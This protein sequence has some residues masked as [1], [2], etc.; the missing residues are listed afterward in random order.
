MAPGPGG[1][2][3]DASEA[4]PDRSAPPDP[5]PA[6]PV[7]VLTKFVDGRAV[8]FPPLGQSQDASANADSPSSLGPDEGPLTL[9]QAYLQYAARQN[10]ARAADIADAP[11]LA[12]PRAYLDLRGLP[13]RPGPVAA[14]ATPSAS[15]TAVAQSPIAQWLAG[16]AGVSVAG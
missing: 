1:R 10:A 9:K 2:R 5:T 15:R 13:A 4:A 12:T 7:R 16:L 6:Q 14:S 3:S 11:A 8:G